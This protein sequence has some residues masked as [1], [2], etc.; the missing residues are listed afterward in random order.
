ML[1]CDVGKFDDTSTN[2][3]FINHVNINIC[4]LCIEILAVIILKE[5]LE[6]VK[7]TTVQHDGLRPICLPQSGKYMEVVGEKALLSGFGL[8]VPVR[9]NIYKL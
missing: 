4:W 3:T 8:T 1:T 6:F 9:K 5:T 2:F 7:G